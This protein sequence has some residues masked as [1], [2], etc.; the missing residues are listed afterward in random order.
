MLYADGAL[1]TWFS[2]TTVEGPG[3]QL[4]WSNVQNNSGV[5][6]EGLA[7]LSLS[8]N[9]F[10]GEIGSL[11]VMKDLSSLVLAS[12]YFS[13][14]A[15][16]LDDAANLAEDTFRE[17]AK[18]ALS[19]L[20]DTLELIPP[21]VNPLDYNIPEY[22]NV[23]MVWSGCSQLTVDSGELSGGTQGRL[24]SQDVI[25]S[26]HQGLFSG[27]SELKELIYLTIPVLVA[28]QVLVIIVSLSQHPDG[29]LKALKVYFGPSSDLG[30][31]LRPLANL[32]SSSL[33]VQLL[34]GCPPPLSLAL[35]LTLTHYHLY[36]LL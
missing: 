19:H 7:E 30:P 35:A 20:G 31:T 9:Y 29:M 27:D 11:E 10:S 26:G 4:C 13:C 23:A 17:P 33:R 2:D 25:R 5:D 28:V 24:L 6:S 36:L 15:A 14:H 32:L 34:L 18:A 1:I 22:D 8:R 16:R 21:F 3:W 12:N